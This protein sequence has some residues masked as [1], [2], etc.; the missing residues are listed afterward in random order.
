MKNILLA[1]FALLLFSTP[2]ASQ[3]PATTD[4]LAWIVGKWEGTRVEPSTGDRAPL[5]SNITGVLDGVGQEEQIEI[6]RTG[7]NPYRGLYLQVFDPK[8]QK[9]VLMYVNATRRE[10]ARLEGTATVSRAEWQ[11]TNIQG[12]HRSKLVYER[13]DANSWRRTQYVSE[14]SGQTWTVLFID[15]LSRRK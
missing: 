4:V 8:L 12:A 15:L 14:D 9:S 3:Q 13:L 6:R 5:I 1:L 2:L 7:K 11:G 10:F